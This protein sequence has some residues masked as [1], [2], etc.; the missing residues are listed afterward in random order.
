MIGTSAMYKH[1]SRTGI[2]PGTLESLKMPRYWI[3]YVIHEDGSISN[4][5]Q[6]NLKSRCDK[7]IKDHQEEEFA[8]AEQLFRDTVNAV[9]VYDE[10]GH[11]LRRVKI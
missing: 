9:K 2:K 11:E 5:L 1:C 3:V 10:Q 4:R 8:A 7:Y 6:T